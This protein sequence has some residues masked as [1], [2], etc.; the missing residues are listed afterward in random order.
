[1]EKVA[2]VLIREL[3]KEKVLYDRN[4][5]AEFARLDLDV[6]LQ[7]L[8]HDESELNAVFLCKDYEKKEWCGLEWRAIR[9]LIKRRNH[10]GIVLL[11]FDDTA[12]PGV[13]ST[14]GYID[15]R[16]NSPEQ[17][18]QLILQRLQIDS[19]SDG[20]AREGVSDRSKVP[21]AMVWLR[22]HVI[23]EVIAGLLIIL[24]VAI[25]IWKWPWIKELLG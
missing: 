24:I 9:D 1:V 3:G 25:A 11:R 10:K 16:S 2:A 5:E 20:Q 17:T 14:D 15:L 19:A 7:K 18:A 22:E 12:I 8:Y 6:Y 23:D 4:F 13:F 21:A